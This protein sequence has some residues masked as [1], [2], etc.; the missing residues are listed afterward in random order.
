MQSTIPSGQESR[1]RLRPVSRARPCEVCGGDHKCSRG[2]D[3]LLV[4]GRPPG[5]VPGFR[6]LGPCK[7][8]PQ[9]GLYRRD[10]PLA[11][12]C[13]RQVANLPPQGAADLPKRAAAAATTLT[14]ELRAELARA[15]GLP[16]SV[17]GLLSGLGHLARDA[18]GPCWTFPEVD[19]AGRVVGLTRR[20]RDGAKRAL[21]GGRRGLTV[22]SGW[23]ERPG[24]V[25]CPEGPSDTL[26]LTALGLAAVGRPS[27][28]GGV[29]ELAM[30]LRPLPADRPIVVLGEFDPKPDGSWPGR[31]GARATAGRL[32]RA[33]G[34]SVL[35]A[36]PPDGCKDVR[37][38]ALAQQ[39][40]P[41]LADGWSLAGE[42]LEVALGAQGR[43]ADPGVEDV[44]A[45]AAAAPWEP[46]V[47]L[48]R[49]PPAAPFPLDV[50]PPSLAGFARGVAAALGCPADFVA[51][52]MLVLA[53]A[54]IGASRALEVKPGW[55]ER[56]CLY[57]A[58]IGRPGSAKSPALKAVAAP[59]Y[60]LQHQLKVRFDA[61][62]AAYL[63]AR[64]DYEAWARRRPAGVAAPARPR[65]PR[66]PRVY[67]S[68]ATVESL[69][70]LLEANPRG[71]VL[72][73]DELTALVT[74]LNQYKAGR[75]SDRQFYLAAWAGEPSC[76]DRR[77]QEAG[78]LLVQHPFLAVVGGLPPDL[79]PCLRDRRGWADGFL[80]RYLFSYPA[81]EAAGWTWD[82]VPPGASAAWAEALDE[83]RL[84]EPEARAD[85]QE[86]PRLLRLTA[87]GRAAW[88]E[89][90]VALAAE[91]AA[92]EFPAGLRDPWAKLR[93]YGARL[94]LVLHELWRLGAPGPDPDVDGA[95]V[96]RA[97]ALVAYFGA[98]ARRA[99][100]ALAA[101]PDAAAAQEVLD[102]LARR[103]AAADFTRTWLHSQ[104][105]GRLHFAAARSL[106]VPLAILERHGYL[107][108]LPAADQ[109]SPGRRPC[110][111]FVVNPFWSRGG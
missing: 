22:P 71:L 56:P 44:P 23:Q 89:F 45:A 108:R 86:R 77:H 28:T 40:D 98:H 20:Y 18:N 47:P 53:G 90:V 48:A 68:D 6:Y 49:L 8:D 99:W 29:A 2:E 59:V 92:P 67:A 105:R 43:L 51:V 102:W 38:W 83:L 73:R 24:P 34:R 1:T 93:G 72:I 36:L 69:A 74:G 94:A 82:G 25:Y 5:E 41:T 11:R 16:E 42:R 78:P 57:A 14:A 109:V 62:H 3:G 31:D 19:A 95:G 50:L 60:Q 33:L 76:V 12:P 52:P 32:A 66:L 100:G 27:N 97:A 81:E 104:L 64:A 80:D 4:C 111:R 106:D 54:A 79:L 70:P 10:D 15:L 103:P 13:E 37:A 88:Q 26:A 107:R 96:R 35:W 84:L 55:C 30:V 110:D 85:G 75:G 9:F 39:L 63:E 101:D 21:A 61:E 58:V 87:C 65:A 46:P 17:L 91:A 7:G